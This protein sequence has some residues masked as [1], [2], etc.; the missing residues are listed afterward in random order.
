MEETLR[1]IKLLN[2]PPGTM[3]SDI[4]TVLT[5]WV[6][7]IEVIS[8][9]LKSNSRI[10][11][12]DAIVLLKSSEHC[13][14]LVEFFQTNFSEGT[15]AFEDNFGNFTMVQLQRFGGTVNDQDQKEVWTFS[16]DEDLT[17]P[18]K[19][20]E[21]ATRNFTTAKIMIQQVPL[22]TE[23]SE[24]EEI[25]RQ[26]KPNIQVSKIDL[27]HPKVSQMKLNAYIHLPEE[28][29]NDIVNYFTE[30]YPMGYE[31]VNKKGESNILLVKHYKGKTNTKKP[32]HNVSN[33]NVRRLILKGVPRYTTNTE[34]K[35]ILQNWRLGFRLDNIF[36]RTTSKYF[37]VEFESREDCELALKHYSEE[38]EPHGGFAFQNENGNYSLIKMSLPNRPQMSKN[39]H[40]HKS[41]TT[42]DITGQIDCKDNKQTMMSP[43][44]EPLIAN[45]FCG[46]KEQ[47]TK[48]S[49][50]PVSSQ[51][52]VKQKAESF[53]IPSE[54]IVEK[55][56]D[57]SLELS[58]TRSTTSNN[59][60]IETPTQQINVLMKE[61][62][63]F[64]RS[65]NKSW[66][67]VSTLEE[68]LKEKCPDLFVSETELHNLQTSIDALQRKIE[69]FHR[70]KI[71]AQSELESVKEQIE[72][73]NEDSPK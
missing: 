11:S 60:L 59:S 39:E 18:R 63:I 7:S 73:L 38:Y 40:K 42:R 1:K 72:V 70:K 51:G 12:V 16:D 62:Q 58:S 9:E 65:I 3:K 61:K 24:I 48:V 71:D 25:L 37:S 35:D 68:S 36:V 56:D 55:E 43:Q 29:C 19:K 52:I 57:L 46:V 64:K 15:F 4:T 44:R 20:L 69:N 54:Q 33:E 41:D 30:N 23:N 49:V 13:N 53:C 50:L 66:S 34:I 22:K 6:A 47:S 45:N 17:M 67:F 27:A 10:K 31:F 32:S 14:K 21:Y 8:V 28:D 2:L 26:W 5:G